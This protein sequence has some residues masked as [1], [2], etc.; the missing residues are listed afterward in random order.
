MAK[1]WGTL[2]CPDYLNILCNL[3]PL[4]YFEG[5]LSVGYGSESDMFGDM[6]VAVDDLANC[7]FTLIR[8]NISNA[9]NALP[10]PRVTGNFGFVN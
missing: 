1:L 3:G 10:L 9:S 6:C 8:S 7:Q 4:A 5:L 2:V